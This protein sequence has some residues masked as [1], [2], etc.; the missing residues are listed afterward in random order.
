MS[1][2]ETIVCEINFD[3]LNAITILAKKEKCKKSL[4]KVQCVTDLY[5][6][7]KIIIFEPLLITINAGVIL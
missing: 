5:Q 4:S 3:S 6:R 1:D 7:N 2:N